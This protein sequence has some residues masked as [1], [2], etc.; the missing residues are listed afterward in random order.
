MA[1]TNYL[2]HF[3]TED[4]FTANKEQLR[5]DA[6][7]FVG[8]ATIIHTHGTDYYCGKSEV[9]LKTDLA[10]KANLEHTHSAA[11]ITSGTL[12]ISRI[13]T[14]TSASTVALGNHTHT[15]YAAS[16]H[17]HS[18]ANI[19]VLTGYTEGTS[20]T[21]LNSAMSL[22]AALAS[23]QN[24]IQDK[25]SSSS[26]DNYALK[27][28]IPDISNLATK[29]ELAGYLPL[30]GGTL[31]G[32]LFIK[33]EDAGI[34]YIEQEGI[35]IKSTNNG[36]DSIA[37][38]GGGIILE[39]TSPSNFTIDNHQIL[40]ENNW[41]TYI[42]VT[43]TK[44]TTGTFQTTAKLYLVGGASQSST[45]VITYSNSNVY[46]QSGQLYATRMNAT[47][48]F[49]ETSDGTL[50]NIKSELN[51]AD[52]ID[53]IPT[54]LFSWKKDESEDINQDVPVH[55]GTIAQDIQKIYPDLVAEDAEG[56]L[57]VDYAKL[58]VI[59]IAAIKELK[60]EIE[61]LKSKIN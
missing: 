2:V 39:L 37:I 35:A 24:Q 4:T 28:E 57:T 40:T 56:H 49:Y 3:K 14:G 47:S 44:N 22:N 13:P 59:A 17:I 41:D 23:L 15:G 7:A 45:G 58:S 46:T 10:G 1:I 9:A 30:T 26:L 51:I 21:T 43:D 8:D 12:D 33:E 20:T 25:V 31:S 54:I 36:Y 42:T 60:K 48:G 52:N 61:I 38:M 32:N 11:D 19:T 55:V 5:N 34:F 29:T 53:K 27:S 18:A 50:K 6:V 16:S